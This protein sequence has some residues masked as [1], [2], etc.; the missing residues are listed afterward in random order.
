MFEGCECRPEQ[1]CGALPPTL[2]TAIEGLSARKPSISVL[3]YNQKFC[4]YFLSAWRPL[5]SSTRDHLLLHSVSSGA[6]YSG[7]AHGVCSTLARESNVGGAISLGLITSF[8]IAEGQF[9]CH[10]YHIEVMM[11]ARAAELERVLW[12]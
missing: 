3:M 12:L 6:S 4:K 2:G 8:N 9:L 7:A 5:M 11:T 1:V 10:P